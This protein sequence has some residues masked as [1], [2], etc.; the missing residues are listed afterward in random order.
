MKR[1]FR[2]WLNCSGSKQA[3]SSIY[4]NKIPMIEP[5]EK[6]QLLA[7]GPQVASI[8]CDN[9][10]QSILTFTSTLK[11]TTVNSA[12]VKVFTAG[13]D[14]KLATA[15][16]VAVTSQLQVSGKLLYITAN[17]QTGQFYR[18]VVT[19][20]VKG[21]NGKAVVGNTTKGGNYDAVTTSQYFVARLSTP[22]GIVNIEL[23]NN[24]PNTNQNFID[25]ANAG[26]WDGTFFHRN[27]ASVNATT[28]AETKSHF[29]L[30]GG[31]FKVNPAG[32]IDEVPVFTIAGGNPRTVIN[33]P[34]NTNAI[35]TIAMAKVGTASSRFPDPV[36]SATNQFFFN[37]QDNASNLDN[38][39]GGFTAFGTVIND[40]SR[41]VVANLDNIYPLAPASTITLDPVGQGP[42]FDST[43]TS[44]AVLSNDSPVGNGGTPGQGLFDNLP[45][46]NAN[47]LVSSKK[48]VP[49]RDLVIIYRVSL[50]MGVLPTATAGQITVPFAQRAAHSDIVTH[51]ASSHGAA[52]RLSQFAR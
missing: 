9:R 35:W 5:L 17:T 27:A 40:G 12:S 29:V 51:V 11:S 31:G 6:R 22:Q 8:V 50:Q 33:E 30:Q 3:S 38:Q 7:A 46:Q 44:A 14:L 21:T 1:F 45:V 32:L 42:I 39:N 10:G 20:A 52:T 37:L 15:D 48:L 34:I 25:Y 2:S 26:Y 16:D 19:P 28:F 23:A 36:N 13:A 47:T 4:M 49:L 18:V 24:T 41:T 43:N